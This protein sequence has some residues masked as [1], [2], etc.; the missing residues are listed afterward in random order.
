[1]L[2]HG[3]ISVIS[4]CVVIMG[5]ILTGSALA[6][7][8]WTKY[9]GNPI[10]DLGSPGTWDDF[11]VREPTILFDGTGYRMYYTGFDGSHLR[12]GLATSADGVVWQK[13]LGNPVLDIGENGTWDD[14]HM[15]GPTVLFDGTGYK[16]WYAGRNDGR[17]S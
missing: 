13:H 12:I 9:V 2:N 11:S 6:Q 3:R 17:A 15:H 10:L 16:M 1:M 14:F 8:E 7:V 5:G 4:L